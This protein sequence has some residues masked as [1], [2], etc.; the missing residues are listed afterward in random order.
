MADVQGLLLDLKVDMRNEELPTVK[1]VCSAGVFIPRL[2]KLN[3]TIKRIRNH[4]QVESKTLSKMTKT[5]RR[6]RDV[7]VHIL[8]LLRADHH[9]T[10]CI[11]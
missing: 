6:C 4:W 1:E 9:R 10:E 3:Q 11:Y 2:E 8:A 7:S 5:G